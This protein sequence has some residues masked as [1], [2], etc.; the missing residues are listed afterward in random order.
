MSYNLSIVEQIEYWQNK[1]GVTTEALA[2][3]LNV[4]YQSFMRRKRL[5]S[6]TSAELEKIAEYFNLTIDFSKAH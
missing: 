5:N 2:A 3:L 1:N 4:S 6:F